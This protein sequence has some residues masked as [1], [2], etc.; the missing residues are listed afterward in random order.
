MFGQ[1]PILPL[2]LVPLESSVAMYAKIYRSILDRSGY[3]DETAKDD[4]A[5]TLLSSL[6]GYGDGCTLITIS[7]INRRVRRWLRLVMGREG[8]TNEFPPDLLVYVYCARLL[9]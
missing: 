2:S 3:S 9:R 5:W 1:L 8:M 6:P 4:A 7:E